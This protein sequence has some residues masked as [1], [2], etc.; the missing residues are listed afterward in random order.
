[1][2][3]VKI[4]TAGD[5]VRY[6]GNGKTGTIEA[7]GLGDD[8]R[9]PIFSSVLYDGTE[10]P[11]LT[12]TE[13]LE[14]WEGP[15]CAVIPMSPLDALE[16]SLPHEDLMDGSKIPAMARAQA[17]AAIHQARATRELAD[18]VAKLAAHLG[19]K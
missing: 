5:R 8:G 7:T 17:L 14:H 1:M 13:Y 15:A 3:A 18:T 19:V 6:M 2:D 12:K 10:Y 16:S 4:F 11:R 9:G